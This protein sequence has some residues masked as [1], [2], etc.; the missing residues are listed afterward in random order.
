MPYRRE[1][2]A[3]Y[4]H[5]R[6]LMSD[7]G[8]GLSISTTNSRVTAAEAMLLRKGYRPNFYFGPKRG[9]I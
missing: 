9:Q 6:G 1:K 4:H 2:G 8:R 5:G 3:C 7:G